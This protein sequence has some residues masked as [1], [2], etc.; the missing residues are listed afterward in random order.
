[1]CGFALMGGDE[2]AAGIHAVEFVGKSRGSGLIE[3]LRPKVVAGVVEPEASER[4]ASP[5]L[6]SGSAGTT[7]RAVSVLPRVCSGIW[8]VLSGRVK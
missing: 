2:I 6:F 7:R 1:M 8:K 4:Y 5:P 3:R